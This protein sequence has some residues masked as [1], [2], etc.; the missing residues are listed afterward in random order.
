MGGDFFVSFN[1]NSCQVVLVGF[2]FKAAGETI[3]D[4]IMAQQNHN[5][6]KVLISNC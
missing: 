3:Y 5:Y 6:N 2:D 4:V 1:F